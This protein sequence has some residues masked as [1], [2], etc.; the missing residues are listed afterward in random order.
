MREANHRRVEVF[1][2]LTIIA[3]VGT[4]ELSRLSER[5]AM[6]S[7][8]VSWLRA[9]GLF[10]G[11]LRCVAAPADTEGHE[12]Q[13]GRGGIGSYTAMNVK[14]IA[15]TPA[16]RKAMEVQKVAATPAARRP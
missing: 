1:M 16:A 8:Q 12:C 2:I 3:S 5:G 9:M 14:K 7:A 13:N 6:L 15:A 4:V 11:A 10:V